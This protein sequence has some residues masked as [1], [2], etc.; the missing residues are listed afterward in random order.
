MFILDAPQIEE[1]A[2]ALPLG[3]LWELAAI[4]ISALA[5]GFAGI[6]KGFD[7][8]GVLVLAWTASLFGGVL[9]DVMIGAFPPVGIANWSFF[10]TAIS[11]GV[12]SYF[13]FPLVRKLNKTIIVLDAFALGLFVWVGTLKGL[14]NRMGMLASASVGVLTAVGGGLVRD[15]LT[16]SV[17]LILSDRKYYAIPACV[18]AV[19]FV[20]L[21]R[22][23]QLNIF[24][25]MIIMAGIVAFRL[26]SLKFRWEVPSP[27]L[28]EGYWKWT[29]HH[30][31]RD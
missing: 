26:A 13:L 1:V 19:C 7:I 4:F 3:Y 10:L 6:R 20:V 31:E 2:N 17:P 24:T 25:S 27:Q 8:F 12:A 5:G 9:R 23:G 18:G 14:D 29:H 15:I 11:G 21:Y 28:S 30:P 16:N 22:F